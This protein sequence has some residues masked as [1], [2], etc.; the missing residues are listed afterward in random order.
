[1]LIWPSYPGLMLTNWIANALP[2]GVLS[3]AETELANNMADL[4]FAVIIHIVILQI[5]VAVWLWIA[6]I[7][8]FSIFRHIFV[9]YTDENRKDPEITYKARIKESR[10]TTGQVAELTG[11]VAELT[12][13][14]AELIGKRFPRLP[15]ISK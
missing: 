12:G 3:V 15:S 7:M 5:A 1:M 6:S 9:C 2:Y 4:S 14:V 8:R 10:M 13:Q 11:Q